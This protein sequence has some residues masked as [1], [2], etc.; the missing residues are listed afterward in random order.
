[1]LTPQGTLNPFTGMMPRTRP[2]RVAGIFRLGLY[3]FDNTYGFVSL[4]VA[5][6]LLN[7]S[8]PEL[9][10]LA[11][12]DIYA[13]PEVAASIPADPRRPHTSPRTGRR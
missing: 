1:M 12:D 5:K 9:I 6:R 11:V 7:K 13:A 3:E 8:Q 2:L 4:D 10:Q